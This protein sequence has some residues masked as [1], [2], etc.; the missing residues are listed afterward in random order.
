[1]LTSFFSVFT[2]PVVAIE[3]G[4]L[5]QIGA[6]LDLIVTHKAQQDMPGVPLTFR[7]VGLLAEH[8][9]P[10]LK[11]G[12]LVSLSGSI[13]VDGRVEDSTLYTYYLVQSVVILN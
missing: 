3:T 9:T 1:M 4:N 11:E 8:W 7:L 5:P 6:Y 12:S 2:G 10:F 13:C